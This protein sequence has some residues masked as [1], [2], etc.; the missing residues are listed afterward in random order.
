MNRHLCRD[1]LSVLALLFGVAGT[2]NAQGLV[3]KPADIIVIHGRVYTENPKQPWAQ[4]VAIRGAKIVAVGEDPA[5]EKMRG[6]GTKVINAGGKLVL[7][8]FTD[9]HIH[10]LDGSLSLGRVNLAGA[11][12]ASDIQKRLREYASEHRG[13]DWILGR[14]WDYAMFGPEALPHKK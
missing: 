13:D 3:V 9:C 2:A 10:F 4:A 12:D 14:G 6:M 1:T 8:A 7:P 5:I 11:K